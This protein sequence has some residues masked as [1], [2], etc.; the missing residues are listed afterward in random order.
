MN[1]FCSEHLF[2]FLKFLLKIILTGAPNSVHLRGFFMTFCIFNRTWSWYLHEYLLICTPFTIEFD[3]FRLKNKNDKFVR[4]YQVSSALTLQSFN[5][6]F[7]YSEVA[8]PLTFT[9]AIKIWCSFCFV[10]FLEMQICR[11]R[12]W[13]FLCGFVSLF[14]L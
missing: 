6:S 2:N 12:L 3:L 9:P 5:H 13:Y 10:E 14:S 11:N 1:F 7:C 8:L 4:P